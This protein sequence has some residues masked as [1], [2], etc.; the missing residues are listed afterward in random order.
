MTQKLPASGDTTTSG[1]SGLTGL[2]GSVISAGKDILARRRQAAIEAPSSDLL[3]KCKQ[4]LHHRGEAS[5]LALASEVMEGYQSLDDANRIRF[6]KALATD[7][8]AD[9]ATVC[10][11][12]RKIFKSRY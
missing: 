6:F 11:F 7:F 5:G 9:H 12:R 3:S 2:L 8:D 10:C 4:L 1:P